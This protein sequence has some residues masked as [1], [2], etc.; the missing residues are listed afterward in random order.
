M[1]GA[2]PP[3]PWRMASSSASRA[4]CCASSAAISAACSE[5]CGGSCSTA[6]CGLHV[7]SSRMYPCRECPGASFRIEPAREVWGMGVW[8][9][10]MVLGYAVRWA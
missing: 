7:V 4:S 10:D 6:M 8:A 5:K 2:D 9:W 3:P 1:R